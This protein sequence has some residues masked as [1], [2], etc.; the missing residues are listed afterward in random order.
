MIPFA[1]LVKYGNIAPEPSREIKKVDGGA[2]HYVILYEN[3]ELYGIGYNSSKQLKDCTVN[4]QY[5]EFLLLATDVKDVWCGEKSTIIY[6]ND[7][8]YIFNGNYNCLGTKAKDVLSS[9]EGDDIT[10]HMPAYNAILK[11]SIGENSTHYIH[12]A[13][14]RVYSRG[15]NGDSTV[16]NGSVATV[17]GFTNYTTYTFKDVFAG[18]YSTVLQGID[19]YLYGCGNSTYGELGRANRS[20]P[21]IVRLDPGAQPTTPFSATYATTIL[22][23]ANRTYTNA[24]WKLNGQLA[25]G[26]VANT[27]QTSFMNLSVSLPA[28]VKYAAHI[29]RSQ[30]G[31]NFIYCADNKFYS[32]GYNNANGF[33]DV[34]SYF[35]NL[36]Y[37]N[38]LVVDESKLVICGGQNGWTLI[39]TGTEL[40]GTGAG[41]S[42]FP[43][44]LDTQNTTFTKVTLPH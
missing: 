19:G 38:S 44:K 12:S 5:Y 39:F 37:L 30:Y 40:Y 3:G 2:M 4:L 42:L 10:A 7:G 16:G 28:V 11:M 24:G 26:T 41:S 43:G 34:K 22:H 8:K 1:R 21:T 27:T 29:R 18:A 36:A 20:W 31:T 23:N 13:N 14:N 25:D 32:T 33:P 35:T 6:T 17:A 9:Q 15:F